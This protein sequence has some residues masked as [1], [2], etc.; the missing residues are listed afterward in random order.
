MQEEQWRAVVGFEGTFSVSDHGRVRRDARAMGTQ[1]G[2]ILKG[3]LSK[4]YPLVNLRHRRSYARV[5]VHSLVMAAFIG[6]RLPGLEVNHKNGINTDNRI[7]N[8]EYVTRSG[9]VIHAYSTGLNR[10]RVR[11]LVGELNGMAVLTEADVCQIRAALSRGVRQRALVR[12]YGV[13]P[14]TISM[15]AR[16]KTW[17]HSAPSSED[18]TAQA[19][20]SPDGMCGNATALIHASASVK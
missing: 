13:C 2:R 18:N 11:N 4:G 14:T 8:L 15:I 17:R 1:P 20:S 5:S 19:L 7:E 3:S 12:Q 16:G 6:P 9:N 10:G